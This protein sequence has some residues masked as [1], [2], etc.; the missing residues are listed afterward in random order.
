MTDRGMATVSSIPK[1]EG[2][3]GGFETPGS[4]RMAHDRANLKEQPAERAAVLLPLQE[5]RWRFR[6]HAKLERKT[7][8][9]KLRL[10]QA[11]PESPKYDMYYRSYLG[12]INRMVKSG[13]IDKTELKNQSEKLLKAD[14]EVRDRIGK[15]RIVFSRI[16]GRRECMWET[17]DK[18]LADYMRMRINRGDLPEIYE[19][20]RPLTLQLDGRDVRV[21]GMS[22]ADR[23]VIA[24]FLAKHGAVVKPDVEEDDD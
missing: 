3:F 19:E 7:F 6:T 22:D 21:E 23:R 4:E 14:L 20:T 2:A 9:V 24:D 1:T 10:P 8:A 18:V 15:F 17:D 5:G 12:W 13:Q 16:R 11:M